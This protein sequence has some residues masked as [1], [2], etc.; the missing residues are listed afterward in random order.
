MQLLAQVSAWCVCINVWVCVCSLVIVLSHTGLLIIIVFYFLP[1]VFVS[2][3]KGKQKP[4]NAGREREMTPIKVHV[5][6]KFNHVSVSATH[7]DSNPWKA[8][9]FTALWEVTAQH[10]QIKI[11]R[12][13]TA[14]S[15]FLRRK[16]QSRLSSRVSAR[17][18]LQTACGLMLCLYLGKECPGVRKRIWHTYTHRSTVNLSP[19]SSLAVTY[20]HMQV[21]C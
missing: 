6:V 8:V 21:W 1:S 4:S 2:T 17:C 18:F 20:T 5:P 16:A 10:R 12:H 13:T 15:S 14:G 11:C 7:R 9:L 19:T 3:Q